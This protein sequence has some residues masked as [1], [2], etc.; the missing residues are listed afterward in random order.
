MKKAIYFVTVLLLIFSLLLV[1]VIEMTRTLTW[2]GLFLCLFI[3]L[4]ITSG[5]SC[6]Y[7]SCL[8]EHKKMEAARILPFSLEKS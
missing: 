6:C 1:I 2:V 8:I 5:C 4:L 3:S 7:E